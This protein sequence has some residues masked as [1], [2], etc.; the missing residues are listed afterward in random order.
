MTPEKRKELQDDLR[1]L[2]CAHAAYKELLDKVCA[3]GR[4]LRK[5]ILATERALDQD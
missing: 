5:H 3:V 2:M 4:R 1:E